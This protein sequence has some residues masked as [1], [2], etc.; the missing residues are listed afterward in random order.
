MST[1]LTN[2]ITEVLLKLDVPKNNSIFLF[3]V[4]RGRMVNVTRTNK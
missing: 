3:L 1:E 2:P 4:G